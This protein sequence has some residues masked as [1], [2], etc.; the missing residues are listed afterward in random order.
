MNSESPVAVVIK[1]RMAQ[2]RMNPTTVQFTAGISPST[3]YRALTGDVRRESYTRIERA[4]TLPPFFLWYIANG[5]AA[6]VRA[7]KDVSAKLRRLAL[8]EMGRT[9]DQ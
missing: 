3:Y 4:L 5:D 9:D 8:D 7:M 1:Y 2:A 6:R